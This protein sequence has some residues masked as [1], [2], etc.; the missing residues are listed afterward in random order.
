MDEL[1]S[2]LV[3]HHAKNKKS[4]NQVRSTA[5]SNT[6]TF[7]E[8]PDLF[9][10][11]ILKRFKLTRI[12]IQ[13]LMYLYRH[14][15]CRP[16]LYAKYGLTSMLAYSDVSKILEIDLEELMNGI[17]TLESYGFIQTVR[18]GQYLVHRYFTKEFDLEYGQSYDEF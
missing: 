10:D 15:W 2:I 3:K 13:I 1:H 14:V 17:N 4:D 9:F 18:A 16:N 7:A 6:A 8:I 11:D 12:E 5:N